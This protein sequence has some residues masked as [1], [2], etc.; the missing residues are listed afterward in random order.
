MAQR[1][2]VGIIADCSNTYGRAILRGATRYANLQRK[3]VIYKEL[4]NVFD[5]PSHW[6]PLDGAIFAGVSAKVFE[7][8]I[9][10]CRFAVQCS[11]S[12]THARCPI[13]ALDDIAVG[14]Q[15]A[16]HLLNCRFEHFGF[17]GF[18]QDYITS[19]KRL[20]GFQ[21]ALK[22][23]GLDCDV[24][25]MRRPTPT[26]RMSHTHRPKVIAWINQL[27][28]PVG[29]LAFDDT[30]AHDLAEA[31]LEAEIAVPEAVAIVGVNNDDLLCESAWPPLS[32]VDADFG[33]IGYTAAETLD[34]ML[35]GTSPKDVD[36]CTLL[37]PLGVVQR[38]STD[39]LAVPNE[40]LADAVRYIRENA[41]VPCT[42]KDVLRHVPVG[43]RWL[44]R[45]FVRYFGR[46][47][48]EEI[49]RVRIETA[50]RLLK[51]SNLDVIDISGR[52]GFSEL[53]TFYTAFR[54]AT[55]TTPAA[56]RRQQLI[57][58]GR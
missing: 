40:D 2:R 13:V 45:Q 52:C 16:E 22:E 51:M 48:H 38:H 8:G 33:R 42:I 19:I 35:S 58:G 15:A 21:G 1:L 7:A 50:L 41:C 12:M 49:A 47:P 24:C 17:F 28:K 4:Q 9:K 10:H 34:R 18:E 6:P 26:E 14:K 29:I 44:E 30:A 11:S 5:R 31:C 56:F 32:S 20:E 46:T 3:W 39:T 55:G 53:K 37:A 36:A 57:G 54:K 27:P 23:R 43:R 25:P